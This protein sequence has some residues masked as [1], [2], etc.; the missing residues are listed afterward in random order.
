MKRVNYTVTGAIRTRDRFLT[1]LSLTQDP[2]GQANLEKVNQFFSKSYNRNRRNGI[3]TT[4]RRDGVIKP[5]TTEL[6]AGGIASVDSGLQMAEYLD[7]EPW[8]CLSD[9][10]GPTTEMYDNRVLDRYQWVKDVVETGNIYGYARRKVLEHYSLVE[11]IE[12]TSKTQKYLLLADL[13]I[14]SGNVLSHGQKVRLCDELTKVP[15]TMRA[16]ATK[17]IQAYLEEGLL[18]P[19]KQYETTRKGDVGV[20]VIEDITS[21]PALRSNLTITS[22]SHYKQWMK[23]P[24]KWIRQYLQ[25]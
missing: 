5:A 12:S 25:C 17:Q 13:D 3:I 18:T 7:G 21:K 11:R 15:N 2:D 6:T 24:T 10:F 4:L 23:H 22:Y 14:G 20:S 9:I 19:E 16:G 1:L 8:S